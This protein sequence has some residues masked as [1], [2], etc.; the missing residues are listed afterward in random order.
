[1]SIDSGRISRAARILSLFRRAE[2][3]PLLSNSLLE[4]EMLDLDI[5]LARE[6]RLAQSEA[7]RS[8]TNCRS[9][10]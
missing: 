8:A 10:A 7:L 5:A 1:L 4:A 9:A 2:K 6:R 3:T